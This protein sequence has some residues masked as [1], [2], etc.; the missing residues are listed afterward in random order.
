MSSRWN[1]IVLLAALLTV[2][3]GC[4]YISG[5][6]GVE[7]A[8]DEDD[9]DGSQPG[10]GVGGGPSDP[11]AVGGSGTGSGGA[12]GTGGVP[13]TGSG[14]TTTN[15]SGGAPTNM[16]PA[17]GITISRIS[18]YQGVERPVMSNG[19]PGS[20]LAPVVAN[21]DAL[22]RVFY[23][24]DNTFD[25]APVTARLVLSSGPALEVQTV[26]SGM[27]SPGSLASTINFDVDRTLMQPGTTYRVELLQASGSGSNAAATY[28]A[29]GQADLA[30][31]SG[32]KL[33]VTVVPI[34]YNGD[35]SGRLPDTSVGQL[36]L[37][38]DAFYTMYPVTSIQLSLRNTVAWGSAVSA[39]GNGWSP[40]LNGLADL[41]Q[42]DNAP[43][44]E[45]YYGVFK[46][47]STHSGYCNGSCIAGLGF[48]AP[49]NSPYHRAAIGLGYSGSDYV[50]IAV[51]E[52]GH[53]HGRGHAPCN[54]SG[55]DTSFPYSDGGLGAWGYHLLDG[56]L[57]SPSNHRDM[58]GYCK[59]RWISD[60]NFG[61]LFDRIKLVD[62]ASIFVPPAMADLMWDRVLIAADG[63]STPAGSIHLSHP[64]LGEEL[65]VTVQSKA[66]TS[67][68]TGQL[69]RYDHVGGGLLFVPPTSTGA[70]L[71][72]AQI[73]G[74]A[75]SAWLP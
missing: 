8:D 67:Q 43:A 50:E 24:T 29:Q 23:V 70:K 31:E 28:P 5:A 10:P 74:V 63:S 2:P 54:T 48:T 1:R 26:P 22:V 51:H 36:Q 55:S 17:D 30:V 20:S 38:E 61:N 35:G 16:L 40:M 33:K 65:T 75:V 42:N 56:V 15:G 21:R 68:V 62:N 46:P 3:A 4:N 73:D 57:V 34:Q 14:P 53:L 41:R 25:G 11:T 32:G 27:S 18:V 7:I 19:G 13:T 9:D 60:Y 39:N 37:L 47:A 69:L 49:A 71:V 66:G 12:P 64:P 44:D 59:P 58:M 6:A 72:Q 52:V 45:Y